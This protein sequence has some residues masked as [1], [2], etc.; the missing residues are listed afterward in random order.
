MLSYS[1]IDG[2]MYSHTCTQTHKTIYI[3]YHLSNAGFPPWHRFWLMNG[4]GKV[5]NPNSF[6]HDLFSFP[7]IT[8]QLLTD[9]QHSQ[10][11]HNVFLAFQTCRQTGREKRGGEKW[12]EKA[13]WKGKGSGRVCGRGG[14]VCCKEAPGQLEFDGFGGRYL[15][16]RSGISE[17]N[18]KFRSVKMNDSGSSM[19][20]H[21]SCHDGRWVSERKRQNRSFLQPLQKINPI[22]NKKC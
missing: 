2:C 5:Q 10:H 15:T 7:L 21:E 16:R 4:A 9:S 13:K 6:G 12:E 17:P 3:N 14:L 19:A 18:R 1:L 22:S 8:K 11:S 20:S